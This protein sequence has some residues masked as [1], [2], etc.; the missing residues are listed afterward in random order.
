MTK[1]KGNN[2][3]KTHHHHN[4]RSK[5]NHGIQFVDTCQTEE[6]NDADDD[7]TPKQK[8]NMSLSPFSSETDSHEQDPLAIPYNLSSPFSSG[9]EQQL[10]GERMVTVTTTSGHTSAR[11]CTPRSHGFGFGGIPK[12]PEQPVATRDACDGH[13][14]ARLETDTSHRERGTAEEIDV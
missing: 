13:I 9:D 6:G 3:N 1:G 12:M 4:T 11:T 2:G 14:P 10:V 7:E 5:H 8:D